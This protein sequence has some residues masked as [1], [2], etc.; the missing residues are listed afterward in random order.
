MNYSYVEKGLLCIIYVG[1]P[2]RHIVDVDEG[3]LGTVEG[4]GMFNKVNVG[5]G[6]LTR[7]GWMQVG[8]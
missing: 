3:H 8:K 2:V 7:V 4:G 1:E 5:R 6:Q